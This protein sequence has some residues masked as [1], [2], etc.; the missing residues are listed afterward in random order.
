MFFVVKECVNNQILVIDKQVKVIK[1]KQI[2]RII[3]YN[4]FNLKC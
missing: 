4:G 2:L 3:K 1:K